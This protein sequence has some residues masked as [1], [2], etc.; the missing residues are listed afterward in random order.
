MRPRY[1]TEFL[2]VW[3]LL[4]NFLLSITDKKIQALN[5]TKTDLSNNNRKNILILP[6]KLTAFQDSNGGWIKLSWVRMGRAMISTLYSSSQWEWRVTVKWKSG[7]AVLSALSSTFYS[8]SFGR[9]VEL[10]NSCGWV[11]MHERDVF[12]SLWEERRKE[13]SYVVGVFF[14][15]QATR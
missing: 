8:R 11:G 4:A 1:L 13:E 2:A 15:R 14:P 9:S 6:P 7:S 3:H 12:G 5:V 10:E